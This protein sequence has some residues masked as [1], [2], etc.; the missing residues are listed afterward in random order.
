MTLYLE[1]GMMLY[2]EQD[3]VLYLQNSR[4]RFTAIHS[5]MVQIPRCV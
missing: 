5:V 3:T 2:L 4:M 1:Q